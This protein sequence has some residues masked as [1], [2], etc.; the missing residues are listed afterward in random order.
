MNPR[1]LTAAEV[2]ILIKAHDEVSGVLG[3]VKGEVRN[4]ASEMDRSMK[5]A[6]GFGGALGD[7][8]KTAAG[9][10][11]GAVLTGGARALG[12]ILSSAV[13]EAR[14]AREALKQTEAVLKSTGG[15]AGVT[16]ADVEKLSNSLAQVTNAEDDTVR[17]AQNLL[18]TFTSIKKDAF[19]QVT[20]LA[21]DMSQALGQDV[22]Q[23]AMQLGKALNDPINGATALRRVGVA[24]TDQQLKQIK[25][26]QESGDML[27]A[28]KVIMTELAT[29]FG[30]SARAAFDESRQLGKAWGELKEGLG[31]ALLPLL[32][33]LATAVLRHVVPALSEGAQAFSDFVGLIQAALSGDLARAATLFNALPR[34]LQEIALWLSR[35]RDTIEQVLAVAR[36]L[37]ED[38]LKGLVLTVQDVTRYFMEHKEMLILVG[39]AIAAL[40]VWLYAIPVAVTAIIVGIGLLR[41]HWDEIKAYFQRE[42]PFLYEL[43][44][45]A[46]ESIRNQIEMVMNIVR[47]IVVIALAVL[48]GDWGAAWE[49]IKQLGRDIWDGIVNDIQAKL[50]LMR[51]IV[52]LAGS[53]LKALW[54]GIWDG[55]KGVVADALNWVIDRVNGVIENINA[56]AGAFSKIGIDAPDIR[57]LSNIDTRPPLG[58]TDGSTRGGHLDSFASGIKYVPRDMLAFLHRGEEVVPAAEVRARSRADASPAGV[59]QTVNVYVDKVVLQG[60]PIAGLAALG[61]SV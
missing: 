3:K 10:V 4:T 39:I 54:Q 16:A 5:S 58:A 36:E 17:Q 22:K 52:G 59:P 53:G 11:T 44:K 46:F 51:A 43:A 49:G 56:I 41:T 19:P 24:L 1:G 21:L 50:D 34:P 28:Q 2:A 48:R 26:F 31:T 35:N 60:D 27:S 13:G 61:V 40:L 30:G 15:V 57:K 6:R 32:A 14:E 55:V 33:L 25:A 45:Y 9:F 12:G 37:G 23:S 47:D 20:E 38:V 7:I 18:L 8:G 42:F 29:E